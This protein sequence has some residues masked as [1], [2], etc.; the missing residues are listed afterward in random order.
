MGKKNADKMKFWTIDE[1]NKFIAYSDNP[2]YTVMYELLFWTGIR[3][4]E[5]LAIKLNDFNFETKTV[6]INKNYAKVNKQDLILNQNTKIKKNNH[7]P[8]IYM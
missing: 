6:S 1:F 7:Y 5:C 4:G 3:I 8:H 2:T